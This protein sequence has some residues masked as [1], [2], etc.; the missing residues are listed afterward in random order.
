MSILNIYKE[1]NKDANWVTKISSTGRENC[2]TIFGYTNTNFRSQTT[3]I[4]SFK[5]FRDV[6][7][8]PRKYW[9]KNNQK[10]EMHKH[11]V[12][13]L[14]EAKLFKRD[15]LEDSMPIFSPTKK[16]ELYE[17][18]IL[19]AMS[20]SEEEK[21]IINYLFLLNGHWLNQNNHIVSRSSELRM[22]LLGLGII[23]QDFFGQLIKAAQGEYEGDELRRQD[24]FYWFSFYSDAD[25][26]MKYLESPAKEKAQLH[27]YII[28]NVSDNNKSCCISKKMYSG[29]AYFKY[30]ME[31]EIK[32]FLLTNILL[33]SASNDLDATLG[34]F[35]KYY[36]S[37]FSGDQGNINK[38]ISNN[39][40]IFHVILSEALGFG[41]TAQTFSSEETATE[42]R[43]LSLL[44]KEGPE[45]F[46]DD[47]ILLGK[48]RVN[49]VFNKR[50]IEVL[51]K[52]EYKCAL[53]GLNN[54]RYFTSRSSNKNYVEV[55]HLIPRQFNNHFENSIE[56][57]ANYTA[58]CPHCH[59]WL[60]KGIDSE[61]E[62]MLK[63]LH[64]L[65]DK[66]LQNKGLT[67]ALKDL[68]KLYG[69]E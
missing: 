61:R 40:D 27:D 44:E 37:N 49:R 56:V 17:E 38:F 43:D 54:C 48:R 52:A 53:E 31:E 2:G 11:Y 57:F 58:L 51:I 9:P 5:E 45:P 16:G 33:R 55:H 3:F 67:I 14:L 30:T 47:T 25:F 8:I 32:V 50:R 6:A 29:G 15:K 42:E 28:G 39:K 19:E 26:L 41:D 59:E 1:K 10:H 69:V 24:L 23:K 21:W 7:G 4:K 34:Y 46:I 64:G 65:R 35:I 20:F 60:H 62:S 66:C 22:L 12:V 63:Y 68:L 36:C 13:P 18:F